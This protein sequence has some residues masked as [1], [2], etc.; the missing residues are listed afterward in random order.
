[1]KKFLDRLS[2]TAAATS[3]SAPVSET[4]L[5]NV[6]PD[7]GLADATAGGG[8]KKQRLTAIS[9]RLFH[10]LQGS[11][12]GLI[13]GGSRSYASGTVCSSAN[14][15]GPSKYFGVPLQELLANEDHIPDVLRFL[16]EYLSQPIPASCEGI[17]R[18]AGSSKTVK[19]IRERLDKS[20]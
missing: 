10:R 1:M 5:P 9:K 11:D 4:D 16:V 3:H 14:T 8:P 15:L 17:F 13:S 7:M 6:K 2:N 12:S 20:E 19:E 18:L